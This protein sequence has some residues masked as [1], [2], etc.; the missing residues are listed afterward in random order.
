MYMDEN[1]ELKAKNEQLEHQLADYQAHLEELKKQLEGSDLEQTKE[2]KVKSVDERLK[3][4]L[5]L[6]Q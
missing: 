3:N 1:E 6:D 4:Y 2:K 5:A